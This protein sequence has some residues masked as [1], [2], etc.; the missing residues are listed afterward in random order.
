MWWQS[1]Q[2]EK[3]PS[4]FKLPSRRRPEAESSLR[5][6]VPRSS[7][8]DVGILSSFAGYPEPVDWLMRGSTHNPDPVTAI[9]FASLTEPLQHGTGLDRFEKFCLAFRV[10]TD[11]NCTELGTDALPAAHVY[12]LIPRAREPDQ[13]FRSGKD[14]SEHDVVV[15]QQLL[16]LWEIGRG[17]SVAIPGASLE[18]VRPVTD[19]D[20]SDASWHEGA[21]VPLHDDGQVARDTVGR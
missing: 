21:A 8:D 19:P 18:A 14:R 3:K 15:I 6:A 10:S 5:V 7:T 13:S 20:R 1:R 9:N 17:L 16:R 4:I 11:K 12:S 2:M